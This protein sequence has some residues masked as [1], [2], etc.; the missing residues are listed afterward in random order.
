[1]KR[2][3]LK[4]TIR[5][6]IVAELTMV[7]KMTT[8]DE[9]ATIAKDEKKDIST[10]K[11][12]IDA[13]KKSGKAVGIAEDETLMEMAK[14]AGDLKS[15]IEKVINSN[16]DAEKKDIRKAIKADDKVK[17]ALGDE[18]LFDNQLNKF[19]DLVKGEREVGQRGR[20]ASEK[21]E[22]EAK[23]K[24]TRDRPK[25]ATPAAKKKEDKPKTFS[26]GKKKYY[27][28]GED[29]EGPSDKEL[30]QL[31]R[32]GGKFDK[33]KLSQLRQQEKTKMVRAFLKDMQGKDI[34]DS[35][36]R[37]LDKDAYAKEWAK[38]KTDIEAKVAT[39]K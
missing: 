5:E 19:I 11:D 29:E 27:A 31:A 33:S 8:P 12:A 25:S 39:I 1:M 10:V 2:S 28:G 24:G 38:A 6:M 7:D 32:S 35:A 22:G 14:I 26:V 21:P 9:A 16:K 3:E 30:K 37:I 23:E 20:K 4:S 34:V 13:A 18:D 15:A 17:A 36:N